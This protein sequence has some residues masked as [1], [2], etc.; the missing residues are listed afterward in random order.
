MTEDE[1]KKK[2]LEIEALKTEI[3]EYRKKQD[4]ID[5]YK[6]FLNSFNNCT[7]IKIELR[8]HISLLAQI[9]LVENDSFFKELS[10]LIIKH[11]KEEIRRLEEWNQ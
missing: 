3:S 6:N 9:D 7:V 10:N 5:G 8:T 2:L 11:Y 1:Y 4:Q